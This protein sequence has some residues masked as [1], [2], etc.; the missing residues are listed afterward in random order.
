MKNVVGLVSLAGL[1]YI[2]IP[3]LGLVCDDVRKRIKIYNSS[4][5]PELACKG[6]FTDNNNNN[7]N[8]NN[9]KVS[10]TG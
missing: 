5:L 2:D 6:Y 7:N 4:Y 1:I 9:K 3:Y 10:T 8:N